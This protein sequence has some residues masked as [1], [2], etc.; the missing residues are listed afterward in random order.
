MPADAAAFIEIMTQPIRVGVRISQSD[1]A[2]WP[3]ES[4]REN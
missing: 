1:V 3:D 2:V 4:L